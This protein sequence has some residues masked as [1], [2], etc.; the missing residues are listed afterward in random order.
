MRFFYVYE[1][2]IKE[3]YELY[4]T[5]PEVS[6]DTRVIKKNSLFF[7]LKGEN[8]NGNQ[9]AK[10]AIEKGAKYV[11][12]DEEE[13]L[14][15]DQCILVDDVL[16]TLQNL[17][18]HHR[19]Q[20][21]IP[22]IGI[23]GTNGKTTTKE[24]INSVLSKKYK[25]IA[26]RGNFNNHIGVPLT[27][28][29]IPN[30]CELAIIE[31]GANHIG[32]IAALCKIAEP[33]HGIITNIGK[34]HIEGFGSK[35]GVIKTKSELYLFIKENDGKIFINKEDQLL[36]TL[37]KNIHQYSYGNN[38]ANCNATLIS[39][40]PFVQLKWNNHTILSQLYGK[41]NFNNIL[42]AIC[43]GDFFN[44]AASDII[45]AIEEYTSSN[46][47]SEIVT[48]KTNTYYLDAYN[49]NPSSMNAAVETFIENDAENKLMILG[50]MLELGKTSEE[51]HQ[52]MV[53]KVKASEINTVFV[54]TEFKKVK[55]KHNFFYC[56]NYQEAV[57]YLINNNIEN[58][59][60]LIKGSRGI[61]LEK[62]IECL[63]KN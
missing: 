31:M 56:S 54:G 15:S 26:T 39:S 16:K 42:A 9:F 22:V 12:I 11:I 23:T 1:M 8:F 49:A 28:L 6:T 32:E 53:N 27:L 37:A 62:I 58:T 5:H 43:I 55:E 14:F 48:I 63:K 13:F 4:Q 29:Q 59:H 3:L 52:N 46:N 21:S 20:L 19:K 61:Q 40:S 7:A 25:T 44:V 45:N 50:D 33:S 30:D 51:E 57:D 34:A 17:A 38:D 35:E 24:L 47:R 2:E 18:N 41:Y 36:L 60:L 10:E